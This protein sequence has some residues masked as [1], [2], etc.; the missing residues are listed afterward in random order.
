MLQNKKLST[1]AGWVV[2]AIAFIVYFLTA[3][4]T[5]SLWDCGEFILGAYK[6]Q[7]VHPPGAP[8]FMI[9]GRMFTVFA[10]MFSDNPEMIAF[11]V[12]LM[13]GICSA[14]A[15]GFVSW[16]TSIFTRLAVTQES[17]ETT[18]GQNIAI[19]TSGLVAGLIGAFCTSVW[20]SAVEGE[21]YAMSTMFT[22]M[23]VYAAAKWY[24][25]PDNKISDRWLVFALFSAGLSV[26]VH[27]LSLLALPAIGLLFYYKKYDNRNL[28]GALLSIGGGILAM[29]FIQKII[30]VGV[31]GLWWSFE[32]FMVNKLGLPFHSGLIPT[33]LALG[34]LAAALFY[35]A[36]KKNHYY[37]QL[38]TAAACL[39]VIA[40]SIIG[41][42]VIRA[43]ADTPV[44][45]NV[46][47]DA[48]RL[49]PYLN[50]EQYGGRALLFGPHFEA[51]LKDQIVEERYGRVGDEYVHTHD[52]ITQI[53]DNKDKMLFPRLGDLTP[54]R[55]RVYRMWW[56]KERG[57]PDQAF[58]LR[59]F[60]QYQLGWMYW[61]YFMWNFVGRQNGEQGYFKWDKASGNWYSGISPIDNTRLYDDELLPRKDKIEQSRNRYFAIPLLLGIL[62]LIWHLGRKRKDFLFL[63]ILFIITGIG[64]IIYSNQPPNEPRERDYVMVG[65]FLT[66]AMWAGMAVMAMY[67]WLKDKIPLKGTMSAVLFSLIGLIAPLLMLTQNFDDHDRS[68]IKASRDYASNFL[69]SVEE[70]A[71]IFTYGDND[72]YPLWY[73]Q[74]VEGIRTDVRVV[75]LSLIAVD[76]YIEK[77]RSKV[78]DSPPIN[79]TITEDSYRGYKRNIIPFN[80]SNQLTDLNR[81]LEVANSDKRLPGYNARIQGYWPSRRM[82]IRPDRE[83]AQELGLIEPGDSTNLD[84]I[85]FNFGQ[86]DRYTFKDETAIMDVI[87]SNIWERPVYFSIT[88]ENSKLM[89][90]NDYMQ[91]EGLALRVVPFKNESDKQR[92][93]AF[94]GDVAV[95]KAYENIMTKWK[96]GNFD[97]ERLFVDDSYSASIGAMVTAMGRVAGTLAISGDTERAAAIS[98]KYFEAFPSMNF[99]Q[100]YE[101]LPFLRILSEAGNEKAAVHARNMMIEAAENLDFLTT[102]DE[103]TLE[104]SMTFQ[105][106]LQK[107]MIVARQIGSILNNIG[108]PELREIY[109]NRLA[110]YSNI[111]NRP[112]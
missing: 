76:W 29:I 56:G 77:L 2:F 93:I 62:G 54:T 79:L 3:E 12:N 27:L 48:S 32:Y 82:M 53:Y 38:F 103:T 97:K 107:Y 17:K 16:T 50:R 13:S 67:E 47:S 106:D 10:E 14:F 88:C 61:R 57:T 8:L 73:A 59:F 104:N 55:K 69:N 92:G 100:S 95:D 78:N 21:V 45:M 60:I 58:N 85:I 9:I 112:N 25:L 30:I 28:W 31:P 72:T 110:Q 66:F 4:R 96:W 36:H 111:G 35:F 26:G 94:S 49:L 90:I 37:L 11:S 101:A 1:L 33:T 6:L 83:A 86:N 65:S 68:G 15:A 102:L 74:E 43:N 80:E 22:M 70:N 87:A 41:V 71:I 46:P 99:D 52:K 18:E 98:E 51:Q 84:P 24:S 105:T 109:D 39:N 63:F 108:D 40:F 91:L 64:I 89:G 34:G 7:V 81:A 19:A 75:N 23:T 5:G 20:F 42:I 44:N